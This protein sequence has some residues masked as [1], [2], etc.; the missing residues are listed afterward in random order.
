MLETN[1]AEHIFSESDSSD[2]T[3]KTYVLFQYSFIAEH[4]KQNYDINGTTK[5]YIPD[6][7]DDKYNQNDQ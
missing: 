1:A 3:M 7:N 4:N 5:F 2:S 6:K